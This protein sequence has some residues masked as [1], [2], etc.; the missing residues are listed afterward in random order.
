MLINDLFLAIQSL[1][2]IYLENKHIKRL[3]NKRNG[4]WINKLLHSGVEMI[5]NIIYK[6]KKSFINQDSYHLTLK[7]PHLL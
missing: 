5:I 1:I 6:M 2:L 7:D 4:L 3:V